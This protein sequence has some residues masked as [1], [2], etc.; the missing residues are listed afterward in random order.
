MIERA[1]PTANVAV[2]EL[3]ACGKLLLRP[4]SSRAYWNRVDVGLTLGEYNIVH[5]L[6][7][8]AGLFHDLSRGLRP[9]DLRRLHRRDGARRLPGKRA[10]GDEALR[11]KFRGLDPTFEEIETYTGVGYSWRKP[12]S[13]KRAGARGPL[14]KR[15]TVLLVAGSTRCLRPVGAQAELYRPTGAGPFPATVVLHGCA[16]IIDNHRG[17]AARL[18][19]AHGPDGQPGALPVIS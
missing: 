4:E 14:G 12:K 15:T 2:E 3:L 5:S 17:R 7:S 9:T 11:N 18:A 10:L 19:S 8:N 16:G 1:K 6:A 13:Y